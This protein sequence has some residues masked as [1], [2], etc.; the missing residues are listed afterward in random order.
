MTLH[1][2]Y[3]GILERLVVG[4]ISRAVAENL[5]KL[6]E[7]LEHGQTQLQDGRDTYLAALDGAQAKQEIYHP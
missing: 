7:L 5:G 2:G 6:K 4:R 1:T 3:P